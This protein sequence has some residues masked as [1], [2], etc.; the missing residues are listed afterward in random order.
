MN[1]HVTTHYILSDKHRMS[2]IDKH[3]KTKEDAHNEMLKIQVRQ[4]EKGFTPD[5]FIVIKVERT[6]MYDDFG[7]LHSTVKETKI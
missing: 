2:T 4:K 3:F 7:F 5:N 6:T 1:T